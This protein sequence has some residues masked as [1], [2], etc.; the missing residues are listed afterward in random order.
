MAKLVLTFSAIV[1]K[2]SRSLLFSSSRNAFLPEPEK[3]E[4][5]LSIDIISMQYCQKTVLLSE[6]KSAAF[7]NL[8]KEF[9]ALPGL[10]VAVHEF[11]SIPSSPSLSL[12][13]CAP[14]LQ[15]RLVCSLI[16][17]RGS[18]EGW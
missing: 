17:N 14:G 1:R 8:Q 9:H 12:S 10:N 15:V 7:H 13:S 2:F 11:T 6:L 18:S 16:S 5:E 4:K 3:E